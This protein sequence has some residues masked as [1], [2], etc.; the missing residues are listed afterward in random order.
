MDVDTIEPGVDFNE[1]IDRAIGHCDVLIALIGPHWLKASTAR[2]RRLD[3]PQ[4]FVRV[5]IGHA[6]ARNIRVIPTLVGGAEMPQADEL[7][8]EMVNLAKRNAIELTDKRFRS[9]LQVLLEP[10]D[11]IVRQKSGR[12]VLSALPVVPLPADG[13]EVKTITTPQPTTAPAPASVLPGSS[14]GGERV[15]SSRP[16]RRKILP[17]VAVLVAV[18]FVAAGASALALNR[19]ANNP[20]TSKPTDL[21][22]LP[23]GYSGTWRGSVHEI[24]PSADFAIIMTMSTGKIATK[25]GRIDRPS[26]G[27]GCQQ[28]LILDKATTQSITMTENGGYCS[29]GQGAKIVASLSGASMGWSEYQTDPSTGNPIATATL[30]QASSGAVPKTSNLLTV[31]D[32]YAGIWKGTA[33]ENIPSADFAIIMTIQSGP[34]GTKVGHVARPSLGG[35]CQQDLILDK[36][37][38]QSITMTE[39]GGY[40]SI[41]QGAK[42]VASLSGASVGWSEYQTDPSTGNPI[43]TATLSQASSGTVPGTSNLLTVPDGFVGTWKGS[44]HEN[45][46]PADFAIIMTIQSG[47]VGSKVGH[48]DRPSLGGGCQQD[49]I[50]D[51]ATAQS[52]TMTENGGYCSI[53]QGAKIVASPSGASMDWQE[54]QTDPSAGSPIATATLAKTA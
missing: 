50:L 6:L 14:T 51:K 15:G 36:A 7:P 13:D 11:R 45:I 30:S 25:V 24:N 21:L 48:I 4:D 2:G 23:A 29:I 52:I 42:I 12:A 35:G 53:G 32:G 28:D 17:L 8:A 1:E 19:R 27:G 18:A 44:A 20:A 9:D 22:A 3:D 41:G 16:N 40:C 38:T 10:L 26:L 49:L 54:F 5:E 47:Q 33:H 31:P 34:V 46:P 37:T 39:N 43:A